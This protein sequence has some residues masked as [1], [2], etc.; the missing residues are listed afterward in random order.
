MG[1]TMAKAG[2]AGANAGHGTHHGAG[3]GVA[4]GGIDTMAGMG[5]VRRLSAAGLPLTKVR[6]RVS[7]ITAQSAFMGGSGKT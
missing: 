2:G 5:G 3:G 6:R 7:V 4:A 1:T